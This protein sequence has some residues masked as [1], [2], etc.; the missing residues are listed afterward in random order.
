MP[1]NSMVNCLIGAIVEV[2]VNDMLVKSKVAA[3]HISHLADKG[4]RNVHHCLVDEGNS[5]N[6]LY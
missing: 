1:K 3:N 6:I 5:V 2:C 4:N